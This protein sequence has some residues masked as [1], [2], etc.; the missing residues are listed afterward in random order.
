MANIGTISPLPISIFLTQ[1]IGDIDID[2]LYCCALWPTY[3][4]HYRQQ[5][6]VNDVNMLFLSFRFGLVET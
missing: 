5:S 6:I 1:N 4:F 2:I 3:I